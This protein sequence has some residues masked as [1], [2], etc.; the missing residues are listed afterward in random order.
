MWDE[1]EEWSILTKNCDLGIFE[2]KKFGHQNW[3]HVGKPHSQCVFPPGAIRRLPDLFLEAKMIP[4]SYISDSEIKKN[5]LRY[6]ASI[7]NLSINTIKL[8]NR[9]ESD[10]LGQSI[11]EIGK[12]EYYKWNGE[13]SHAANLERT[14]KLRK[15]YFPGKIY[16]QFK[17]NFLVGKTE[18][19]FRTK[20]NQ[21]YPENL[22][23]GDIKILYERNGFS[24]TFSWL[25]QES[26]ELTDEFNKWIA[27]F[28]ER[29]IRLFY[30]A[31]NHQ[32][33]TDYWIETETLSRTEWMFL[34]SSENRGESIKEWGKQYCE[35][36]SDESYL[37]GLPEGYS[38]YKFRNPH[39]SHDE[40]SQLKVN[41][42][43]SI[44][45]IGGLKKNFRVF[46]RDSLPE[47]EVINATGEELV[48][49]QYKNEPKE[50]PLKQKPGSEN[51]WNLP[52]EIIPN[53]DFYIKVKDEKLEGYLQAY[54][55]CKPDCTELSNDII[56]A[57]NIFDSDIHISENYLQGNK[58]VTSE[59]V[60]LIVN[61]LSLQPITKADIFKKDY[62]KFEDDLLLKWLVVKKQCNLQAFN[63]SFENIYYT[64]FGDEAPNV[65]QKRFSTLY[66][67]DYLG[68]I[69]Y[70]YSNN[71]LT[72]LPPK[73][74]LISCQ[75]GRRA[76]LIGGRD[77]C[78]L[79]EMIS[80]CQKTGI[81]VSITIQA[82]DKEITKLLIPNTILLESNTEIQFQKL[83]E[84]I[85][86]EYDPWYLLKLESLIPSLNEYEKYVLENNKSESHEDYNWAR[87]VFDLNTLKFIHQDEFDKTYSL[88]EYAYTTYWK[89]YG[90]WVDGTYYKVDKSWGKYLVLNHHSEKETGY[91]SNAKYAKPGEIYLNEKTLAIP[92]S[93]P[94]PKIFLRILLQSSSEPP[95]FKELSLNIK[96]RWYNIYQNIPYLFLV[97]F[98]KFKLNM[99]IERISN[100]RSHWLL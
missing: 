30:S 81:N 84:A 70:D 60:N 65:L 74:I 48:F 41:T 32:L 12:R 25:Y 16:L 9:S 1:L 97:N 17:L 37:D 39:Q 20:F 93:L 40:I 50:I 55:I 4:D 14:E 57:R 82:H 75:H 89:E 5:L 69:D 100:E 85:N 87:Q 90:L 77:E 36:F 18:F 27:I 19:S 94:L 7:L 56:C 66:L 10:E 21:E 76:M 31:G 68:Y 33:S 78:L 51:H 67:L 95:L 24:Q 46:L 73:L 22:K 54:Q 86:I 83:A 92:A 38:L 15:T 63:E 59:K 26:F 99:I 61:E 3:V 29:S 28:P 71:K 2:I 91:N 62:P 23:L 11:I 72:A 64:S 42:R 96:K 47:V 34:M 58:I 49:F 43:K 45:L 52:K 13:S 79:K 53:F 6:G 8:I 88:V 44:K 98:F 35:E 80:Y